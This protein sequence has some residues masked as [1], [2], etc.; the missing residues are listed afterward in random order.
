MIRE[1]HHREIIIVRREA[2]VEEKKQGEREKSIAGVQV[3]EEV[4]RPVRGQKV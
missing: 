3:V 4:E 1:S 2:E